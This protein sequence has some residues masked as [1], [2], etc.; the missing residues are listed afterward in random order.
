MSSIET[1]PALT[2]PAELPDTPA[3]TP[4]QQ[5]ELQLGQHASPELGERIDSGVQ[6][7]IDRREQ[8]RIARQGRIAGAD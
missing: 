3:I 4:G 7:E 1:N 6:V 2:P 8:E 5:S